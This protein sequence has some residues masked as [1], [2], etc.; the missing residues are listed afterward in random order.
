MSR[1]F[2]PSEFDCKCGKPDCDAKPMDLKLIMAL[3]GLRLELGERLVITSARR[4]KE[5]NEKIGGVA[6]S[7]HLRGMA[8]DLAVPNGA[9]A[10]RILYLAAVRHN[11]RGIGIG[12][13]FVHLDTRESPTPVLFGY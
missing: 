11:F 12:K 4:C 13:T 1:F 10:Y 3:D 9:M 7:F 2:A 6:N 5:H 8:V